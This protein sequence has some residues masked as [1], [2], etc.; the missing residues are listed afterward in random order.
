MAYL[1]ER[2]DGQTP[3]PEGPSAP[4]GSQPGGEPS[5]GPGAPEPPSEGMVSLRSIQTLVTVSIIAGP[6]SMIVGGVLLSAVA[7]GCAVAALA[8]VRR[9]KAP[10]GSD[11]ALVQAV[12][13]QAMVGVGIGVVALTLNAV[14][15]ALILPAFIEAAQTGDLSSLLGG[16]GVDGGAGNASSGSSASGSSS[17][18]G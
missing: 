12:R 13:R 16:A 18:W 5:K 6:V 17:V 9:V 14:S 4:S 3:P 11:G 10:E 2:N 1:S 15:V 7:L 8:K